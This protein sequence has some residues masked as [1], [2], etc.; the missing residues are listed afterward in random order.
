MRILAISDTHSHHRKLNLPEADM[1]ISAGDWSFKGEPEIVE[2]FI[3]WMAELPYK[4][5]V[6]IMGNH[7]L[8]YDKNPSRPKKLSALAK[9]KDAGIHYLENN[10]VV[11]EG[12]NIWGSPI[13][14]FFHNWAWNYQ[15]GPEIAEVWSKIPEDTNILIT[16]GPP[17]GKLDRVEKWNGTSNEG[18]K[19]LKERVQQL[20]HLKLHIFG[21][22]H[23]QG[24]QMLEVDGVKYWN[25]AVCDEQ[26]KPINN[27]IV[28]DI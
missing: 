20:K 2:D 27:I 14:P 16:H 19:D 26:Y 5:K 22:M 28:V 6:C 8:A 15:R 12:L 17:Y 21:H 13:T 3:D 24:G 4:S 9:M 10:E 18:C 23:L 25:A 7:E 1:I 11:I